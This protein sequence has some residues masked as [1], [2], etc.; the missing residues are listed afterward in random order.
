MTPSTQNTSETLAAG[1]T[2]RLDS[3]KNQNVTLSHPLSSRWLLLLLD[4][5]TLDEDLDLVADDPLAIEH[6]IECQ[7]KVLAV[8]PGLGTVADAVAMDSCHVAGILVLA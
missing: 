2:P 7:A 1:Y 5:L 6:H 8:D 4:E 3:N